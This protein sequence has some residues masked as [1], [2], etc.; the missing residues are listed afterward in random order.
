MKYKL[1]HK[2]TGTKPIIFSEI[3]TELDIFDICFVPDKGYFFT[4]NQCLGY[5]DLKGNVNNS[6]IGKEGV[7]YIKHGFKEGVTFSD[8]S[9]ICFNSPI[10]QLM[11][12]EKNG[13][14]LRSVNINDSYYCLSAMRSMDDEVVDKVFKKPY[15][16]GKTS[17]FA[18]GYN[19][20]WTM[21][22]LNLV[23][24]C[25]NRETIK[26][27]GSGKGGYSSASHLGCHGISRPSGLL[28]D[29]NILYVSDK[30]NHCIR[31]FSNCDKIIAG[32]PIKSDIKPEKL[33][34]VNGRLY[35]IDR[36][37]VKCV[38]FSDAN[39]KINSEYDDSRVISITEASQNKL[40]ILIKE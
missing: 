21:E 39:S 24:N 35:F 12:V 31:S 32:H 29:K 25:W 37:T 23:F 19:V 40:A 26:I 22:R 30:N 34:I 10:G 13:K 18:N 36:D 14:N 8:P 2:N 1:L 28:I 38:S 9:A 6:F 4:S 15:Q 27:L 5:I 7:N 16:V 11:V 3:N 20:S 17:I 33:V